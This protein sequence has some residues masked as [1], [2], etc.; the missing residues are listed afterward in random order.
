[1]ELGIIKYDN[2]FDYYQITAEHINL[3]TL[4]KENSSPQTNPKILIDLQRDKEIIGESAEKFILEYEKNRVGIQYKDII[5]HVALH[6][7]SAGYDLKSIT[8][9]QNGKV[10]PRY[11]EVKAVPAYSFKFYW[12]SNE[13]RTA[14]YLNKWYYLYLLPVNPG[15]LFALDRLKIIRNPYDK[16]LNEKSDWIVEPDVLKCRLKNMD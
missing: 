7:A 2:F 12:T 8:V 14:K 11:I 10:E 4:A 13:V 1:M 6:N 5:E 3:F 9:K 15:G 16:V